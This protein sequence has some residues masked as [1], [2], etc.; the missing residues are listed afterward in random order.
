MVEWLDEVSPKGVF[1][2]LNEEIRRFLTK[3]KK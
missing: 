3:K 2:D 1:R